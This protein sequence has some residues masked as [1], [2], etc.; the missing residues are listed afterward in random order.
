MRGWAVHALTIAV[1]AGSV[2][3]S[4][5]QLRDAAPGSADLRAIHA[6]VVYG[7]V[8]VRGEERQGSGWLL[9]QS[10][11]PLVITNRHVVL[12]EDAPCPDRLRGL[13]EFEIRFYAGSSAPPATISARVAY[14]SRSIDLAILRLQADPPTSARPL[15]MRVD[16]DVARGERVVLGGNPGGNLPFQTTE[17][18]VTGRTTRGNDVCGANRNCVVIDAASL[19]GCSGGPVFNRAGQLVGM[20]WGGELGEIRTGSGTLRPNAVGVTGTSLSFL[21][22]TRTIAGEL[23]SLERDRR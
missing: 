17:G 3:P 15:R 10:G 22:H 20:V 13:G 14:C 2:L 5:A 12:A 4:S 9:A 21:I 11:R 23:Q 16:T 18:V 7:M 6:R 1:V 19:A 8:D